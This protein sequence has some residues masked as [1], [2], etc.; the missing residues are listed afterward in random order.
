MGLKAECTLLS[1]LAM[2]GPEVLPA[3]SLRKKKNIEK[4]NT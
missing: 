3:L 4:E 1:I 2:N